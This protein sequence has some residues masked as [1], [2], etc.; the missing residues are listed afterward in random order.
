VRRS[1]LTDLRAGVLAL[2]A[3]VIVCYLGFT[4]A[5]NPF[6]DPFEVKAAF[7]TA[8]QIK[9]KSPVRIAGVQVG[10]VSK[11]ESLGEKGALVTMHIDDHGLP[12]HRDARAKIRPRI[13][14]EGNYFV[15]VEPGSPSAPQLRDGDTL[16]ITQTAAPVGFGRV[17]ETFQ[18]S[19]RE[20]LKTLL[21]ELG[22]GLSGGGAKGFNR[23]TAHMEGA[24]R[25][26]AI[27]ND[28]TRGLT[29]RDLSTYINHAGVVAQGLDR[30]PQA[31]KSLITGFAQTADAL[32]GE[33][34][35]LRRAIGTLD[36]TLIQGHDAFGAL[37]R[38]F[39]PLRRL[40]ADLRPAAR[41]ARPALDAQLELVPQLRRLMGSDELLGLAGELRPLVPELVHLNEG[42]VPLQEQARLLSSCSLQVSLPTLESKV[43]DKNIEPTGRVYEEGVK[44]LPGIA[45][46]SRSFDG[47]GQWIKTLAQT[48]NYAYPLGDG[49][50]FFTTK[51]LEGVN[52][53]KARNGHPPLRPDVPCETQEPPDLRTIPADPPKAIKVN[54]DTPEYRERAA[55]ALDRS[56]AWLTGQLEREGLDGILRVT[57]EPVK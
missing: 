10:K 38:A 2:V 15:D 42:G 52:P 57:K 29:E 56:V 48:A 50:F 55:E 1:R 8:N 54:R 31:L 46:E 51:P 20:D 24:F 34:V 7:T 16:P 33:Q 53:P 25:D 47:N 40:V 27:V 13:F 28:A 18:H 4:K 3:V 21:S 19:T 45:G 6:A 12:L 37:N 5:H 44:W 17:L 26:S 41:A 36:D 39:P 30:D 23:A 35:S 9:A 32:A 43:P 49:R 14:L 22:T 11:V